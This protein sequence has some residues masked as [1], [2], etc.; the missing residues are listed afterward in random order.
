MSSKPDFA[1]VDFPPL[2]AETLSPGW[3]LAASAQYLALRY[4]SELLSHREGAWD[5]GHPESIHQIRV[6]ARRAR[7]ALQTFSSL[8]S[9]KE[10]ARYLDM[11]ADFASSFDAARDLDTMIL[12]LEAE[13]ER[14]EGPR[15]TALALL[16]E[17]NLQRRAEVQPLI[18]KALLRFEKGKEAKRFVE[19]F[20]R[21]PLD[22]WTLTSTVPEPDVNPL[23]SERVH[24]HG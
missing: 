15:R 5:A 2:V 20:S 10:A 16:L 21:R 23:S 3:P 14:A 9:G 22:L 19:F 8:W 6:A 18:R 4:F 13:V 24:R 1:A 11:L 12:Y 17:H 7:T